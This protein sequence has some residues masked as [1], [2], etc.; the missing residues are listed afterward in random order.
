MIGRSDE[1]THGPRIVCAGTRFRKGRPGR[2]VARATTGSNS[3][4]N[5]RATQT[6]RELRNPSKSPIFQLRRKRKIRLGAVRSEVQ[7]LSPRLGPHG[8]Q[9]PENARAHSLNGCATGRN[10]QCAFA[11][12]RPAQGELQPDY[13]RPA[14]VRRA[15]ARRCQRPLLAAVAAV[16][17]R[18]RVLPP[19][20]LARPPPRLAASS[21][22]LDEL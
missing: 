18:L 10:A 21:N 20:C 17:D 11:G 3:G 9:D 4:S 7:I 6:H 19:S 22:P 5:F 12:V 8:P 1:A 16:A 2:L 15:F 14:V 13:S